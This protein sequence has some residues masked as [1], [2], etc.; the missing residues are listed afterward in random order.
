MERTAAL[1]T[2]AIGNKVC[3]TVQEGAGILTYKEICPELRCRL[4][5]TCTVGGAAPCSSSETAG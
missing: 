1:N 5:V 3:I 2:D 4:L